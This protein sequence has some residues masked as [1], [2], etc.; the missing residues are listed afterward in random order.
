MGERREEN[1][2]TEPYGDGINE[3]ERPGDAGVPWLL[4][5]LV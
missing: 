4:V 1:E 2:I 3:M 5:V